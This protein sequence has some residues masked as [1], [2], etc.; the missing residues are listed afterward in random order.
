MYK[1]L[2]LF[3]KLL[4]VES[5]VYIP[6]ILISLL[7]P[8]VVV[9]TILSVFTILSFLK[10]LFLKAFIRCV[11]FSKLFVNFNSFIF[12][13]SNT[14]FKFPS[15]ISNRESSVS[16]LELSLIF[17]SRELIKN[18]IRFNAETLLFIS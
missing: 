4:N 10:S 3:K 15:T 14:L 2:P 16:V 12:K 17:I 13:V 8:S 7:I 1:S 11:K 18:F 6:L 9:K 5:Y